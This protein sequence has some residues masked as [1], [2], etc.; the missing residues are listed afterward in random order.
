[1]RRMS[2]P[3]QKARSPAPRRTTAWTSGSRAHSAS[4]GANARYI[5]SVIAFSAFGRLIVAIPTPPCVSKRMSFSF[6][7]SLVDELRGD[8]EDEEARDRHAAGDEPDRRVGAA[9]RVLDPADEVVADEAG[10]VADRV[11][12][13][14]AGGGGHAG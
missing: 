7:S 3:A 10:D 12:E 11:H 13:G 8:D 1:M 9:G 6:T 5:P 2:P 14:D 4:R